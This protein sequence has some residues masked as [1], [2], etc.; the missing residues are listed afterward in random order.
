MMAVIVYGA[1]AFA[2]GVGVTALLLLL[3]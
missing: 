3:I 2:A 1:A